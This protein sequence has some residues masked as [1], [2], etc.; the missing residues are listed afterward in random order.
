MN[1]WTERVHFLPLV[2]ALK[3]LVGWDSLIPHLQMPLTNFER[4]GIKRRI[5]FRLALLI[6]L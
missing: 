5:G 4:C 2:R 1:F 3:P 6:L